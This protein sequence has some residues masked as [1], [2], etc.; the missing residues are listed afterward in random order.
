MSDIRPARE[1]RIS[2]ILGR[3]RLLILAAAFFLCG[4]PVE[5]DSD[6]LTL[7]TYHPSPYGI[8]TTI[9]VNKLEV[10]QEASFSGTVTMPKII[11]VGAPVDPK[12][13]A[14]K[15]YVEDLLGTL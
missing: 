5:V 14:T 3:K 11:N 1:I 8:Y 13:A 4:F 2:F 15:K 10:S 7:S 6:V 12:D 9:T